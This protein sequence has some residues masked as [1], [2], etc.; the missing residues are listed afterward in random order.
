MVNKTTNS[1]FILIIYT[2][3][4]LGSFSDPF[5]FEGDYGPDMNPIRQQVFERV[6][7]KEALA[8]HRT[9]FEI[10]Q[11]MKNENAGAD[12]IISFRDN[13][14]S[15]AILEDREHGPTLG[16]LVSSDLINDHYPVG[17]SLR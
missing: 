9:D 16:D 13:L 12:E 8:K 10:K 1:T 17:A 14:I 5:E 11:I 6:V 7:P 2:A 3:N 15:Q 4:I